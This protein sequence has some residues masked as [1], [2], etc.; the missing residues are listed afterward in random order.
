MERFKLIPEAHLLLQRDGA[1]LLLRRQNT[2][3]E[4]GNYSVVAGHID[5][6]EPAREAMAREAVEEA[7]I[8]IAP[9]ALEL[10]HI[11]HRNADQERISFFFTARAWE[12]EPRNMEPKWCDDL[13]W[14]DL[15]GLPLNLIPYVAV[16]IR[17]A[18]AGRTYSEFGW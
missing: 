15:D 9:E 10:C 3:Y 4:D 5:G 17:L 1:I 12:G 8:V 14:F 16:A 11:M 18:N 13:S 7:G 6:G 2:G